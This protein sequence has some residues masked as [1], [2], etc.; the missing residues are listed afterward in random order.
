MTRLEIYY[1]S[2][3]NLTENNSRFNYVQLN[4]VPYETYSINSQTN[5]Y[6]QEG[7]YS[8]IYYTNRN[9]QL[10]N[11]DSTGNSTITNTISIKNKGIIFFMRSFDGVNLKVSDITVSKPTFQSGHYLGKD[12]KVIV[13]LLPDKNE[14][15]K[16]TFVINE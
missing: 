14:T 2:N 9:V 8:G 7:I 1:I 11:K 13:E 16:I 12:M 3:L 15:I 5:I 6:S 4:D 10:N